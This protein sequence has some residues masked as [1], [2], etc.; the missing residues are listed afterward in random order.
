MD[1]ALAAAGPGD[2]LWPIVASWAGSFRWATGDVSGAERILVEAL[3]RALE[4]GDADAAA[5]ASTCLGMLHEFG[6]DDDAAAAVYERGL[7][8]ARAASDPFPLGVILENL[9]DVHHR[10]GDLERAEALVREALAVLAAINDSYASGVALAQLG[11]LALDRGDAAA[12]ARLFGDALAASLDLDDPWFV[13]GAL[14]GFAGVALAAGDPAAAA[15]LLGAAEARRAASGR[16]TLPH[17]D[18]AGRLRDAVWGAL[19]PP[20]FAAAFAAGR[21]LPVAKAVAESHSVG[22]PPPA[23]TD[24]PSPAPSVGRF[25]LSPR[26]REVL[27][28]L[29]AGRSNAEIAEALF[30]S[31]RTVTTHVTRIYEKLGVASRAEAV[32]VALR[33]GLA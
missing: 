30:V 29:A 13:G 17:F 4:A 16:P 18:Q 32:A 11:W 10:R 23:P 22:A 27:A 28:L 15:R 25:G 5:L 2:P 3:G 21:A 14:A 8:F 31:R 1:A 24:Q 33:E 9:G 7:A 26:E 12:A 20:A 6:R 19:D